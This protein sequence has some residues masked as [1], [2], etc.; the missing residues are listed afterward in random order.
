MDGACDNDGEGYPLTKNDGSVSNGG[1]GV[2]GWYGDEE[3]ISS[4]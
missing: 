3:K 4:N 2:C 1:I